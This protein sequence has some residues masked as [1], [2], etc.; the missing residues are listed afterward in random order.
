MNRPARV[1]YWPGR[2]YTNLLACPQAGGTLRLTENHSLRVE[3][4]MSS[5]QVLKGL[6]D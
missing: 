3:D 1:A 6:F 4:L 2:Q 5:R